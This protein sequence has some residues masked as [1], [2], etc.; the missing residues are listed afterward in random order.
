MTLK[1]LPSSVYSSP[2]GS[3]FL[4]LM[5]EQDGPVLRVFHWSTF[6]TSD[7][8]PLDLSITLNA[9]SLGLSS[10]VSR[11]NVHLLVL[12]PYERSCHSIVLNI[13]TRNTQFTFTQKS[14]RSQATE[15]NINAHNSLIDCHSEV[16]TRF[17]VVAAVR[18]KTLK[19]STRQKKT[20]TFIADHSCHAIPAYFSKMIQLF[21]QQ[22][23][24]PTDYELWNIQ[25]SV[26]KFDELMVSGLVSLSDK[27]SRFLA[28]EWLVDI[29]CLIPIQIAVARDNRFIPLKDGLFSAKVEQD[30][31]GAEVGHIVNTLSF[32]WYESLFQSY[33]SN[34]ANLVLDA[35]EFL[36][37]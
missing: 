32:G 11:K 6:G 35:F 28:G 1:Q 37:I 5:P 8:I 23:Q 29:L 26:M 18:R 27:T 2:D 3:C 7:G 10:F 21:E 24:K 19:S 14:A 36:C 25:V 34:K 20:L 22:T 30:L 31:L 12:D 9:Q 15:N 13:T 4:A 33:Q 16:W 17:P